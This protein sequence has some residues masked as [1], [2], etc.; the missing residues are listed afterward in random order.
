MD[1][2]LKD[3]VIIVTGGASGIGES[4]VN[5]LSNEGAIPCIIDYNQALLSQLSDD[6]NHQDKQ[7]LALHADLTNPDECI[8]AIAE[9]IN[10]YGKIDG[11]VNNAGLNDG[12]SLEHGTSEA[13][14]RSL[15]RNVSHYYSMAHFAIEHL[16]ASQ[17]TIVNICSKV[18]ETGQGGTSGYA[19]ANGIRLELT[20]D[21][22]QELLSF[23]VRVNAVVVAECFTPQYKWWV[24]QQADPLAV[25]NNIREKIPLGKRLTT[26][27]EI[28]E[29]TIFL[30]S[31]K[32]NSI[33]GELFHVDG[34]Y[35]HL[36]RKV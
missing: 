31:P 8:K 22:A 9:I 13:F 33:N 23:G 20:R 25:L 26:P 15:Q 30:L 2:Q 3:K 36:D 29:T 27:D 32:S 34:G 4:I 14:L 28:A 7:F 17:G 24:N 18:A 12:V 35:V 10:K 11:L 21:W 19:A 6:Y 1:L 5:K 16:K